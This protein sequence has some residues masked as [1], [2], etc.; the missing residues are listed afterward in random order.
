MRIKKTIGKIHLWLGLA[1]GLVVLFL[2]ITGCILAFQREIESVSKPYQYVTPHNDAYIAPSRMYAIANAQLPGK[3][4]HSVTYGGKD[5]AVVV[6]FYH[7]EPEYYYLVYLDPYSGQVLKVKNMDDDFFRIVV[8]GHF[9]LWLPPDIGKPIVAS[10]TLVFVVMMITG[11]VLWWPK[12]KAARK[13]RFS[14]KWSAKWRRVN[15]D[16]HNVLGFYMSWVAIFIAITGLVWGFQWVSISIYWV[17][18][19]GKQ[20]VAFYEPVSK[21]N[22]M[23]AAGEEPAVDRIWKK[24]NAEHATAETI[25]VHFPQSDTGA[26]EAAMN[27][28]AS[29]YWKTDYRYFDQYSLQEVEV[30][31]AYG[32]LHNTT[33]ADK[34]ARMNYDIHVGA[35]WGLAGKVLAFF[36]SL[37]AASLPVTGFMIWW[38]RRSKKVAGKPKVSIA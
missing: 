32:R 27:P 8:N 28:D 12:N 17:A 7:D 38:G 3:L 10:A 6:T 34:I 24:M 26:I 35:V 23:A 33:V 5:K 18:S 1:S 36:A 25:E 16:M 9:Y 30:T 15:Y 19:G 14:V 20:A 22:N 4:A 2:G 29:T 11:I 31:H 37:L 13:Q 21:K